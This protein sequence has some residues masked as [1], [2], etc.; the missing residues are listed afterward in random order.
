MEIKQTKPEK[1][2]DSLEN[3]VKNIKE[4]VFL[5]DEELELEESDGK[6]SPDDNKLKMIII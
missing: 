3:L 5:S 2:T 6:E 4:E 1:K